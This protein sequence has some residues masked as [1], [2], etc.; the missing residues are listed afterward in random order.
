M[1]S[2]KS[3]ELIRQGKRYRLSG[4]KVVFLK[5]MFDD[6]YSEDEIVTHD[7]VKIPC[8][9]VNEKEPLREQYIWK[10]LVD[11]QVVCIDEIQFFSEEI[12]HDINSLL[13]LGKIV[14]CSGLDLNFK[15]EIF[16]VTAHLMAIA[17]DVNKFHAICRA[18]GNEAYVSA[19]S[20]ISKQLF[21]LGSSESYTPL[22]RSC[23]SQLS[24]N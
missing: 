12:I 7:G 19:R 9:N 16:Y 23:F 1:F 5:P 10:E 20:G 13:Q 14:C 24:K 8:K 18:C 21:E 22:C 6:R 3:E 4:K 17:D 11:T 15:G 2:G